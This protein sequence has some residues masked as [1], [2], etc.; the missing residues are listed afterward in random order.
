M[1]NGRTRSRTLKCASIDAALYSDHL[2][3]TDPPHELTMNAK[4]STTSRQALGNAAFLVP[5]FL[6]FLAFI[7]LPVLAS[8]ILAF[9]DWQM[10]TTELRFIGLDNFFHLLGFRQTD[11]GWAPRDPL[12]WKYLYNTMYLMLS[13][14]LTMVLSLFLALAMNRAIRGIAVFRVMF[15]TPS[16][17]IGV[18]IF[19][20]WRV[21]YNAD[22]GLIN[23]LL[24]WVNIHG[25]DWLNSTTWAKPALILMTLWTQSGGYNMILYLAGLQNIPPELYE[26]AK[27]D[28]AG[29]W[30]Q[31]VHITWPMLAPTT[32][33]IFTMSVIY[34]FQGGFEAAYIMTR[35]G[36]AGSTTTL[37]YYIYNT[38][39]TGELRLGYGSAIAWVLFVI[40]LSVTLFNWR[41]GGRAVTGQ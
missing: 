27:V 8:L 23:Q 13:I 14:P 38:A 1:T 19:M 16:I 29:R 20:V 17:C 11:S 15:F 35:G 3:L 32:F 37:S 25:P 12:F 18:A 34:G 4:R 40:V 26:A 10:L 5:N 7:F 28:G 24:S 31:L 33:F 9:T 30:K 36:P 22:F 21:M 2:G 39:Y 6:G 41:F